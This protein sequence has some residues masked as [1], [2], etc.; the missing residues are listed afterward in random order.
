[1]SDSHRPGSGYTPARRVPELRDRFSLPVQ[2]ERIDEL[3]LELILIDT[4]AVAKPH[5]ASAAERLIARVFSRSDYARVLDRSDELS[6]DND[7]D[8]GLV[9]LYMLRASAKDSHWKSKMLRW[10][11]Y[12]V[13]GGCPLSNDD[14]A[15]I[16]GLASAM[17]ATRECQALF[18]TLVSKPS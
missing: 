6:D 9:D 15:E 13:G 14:L 10:F 17:G 7:D 16:A 18:S 5:R 3:L 11:S 8:S 1:M 12:I 2:T 4:V